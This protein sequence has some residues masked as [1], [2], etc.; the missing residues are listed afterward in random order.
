MTSNNQESSSSRS[1]KLWA[2][3]SDSYNLVF[4]EIAGFSYV[5]ICQLLDTLEA[6]FT[7][8]A[9]S[10]ET[11]RAIKR[12]A[13]EGR[14]IA[15]EIKNEPIDTC[16]SLLLTIAGFGFRDLSS[17]AGVFTAFGAQCR[18]TGHKDVGLRH[19]LPLLSQIDEELNKE[20]PD[21]SLR[22]WRGTIQSVID[23]LRKT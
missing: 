7:G 23:D 18:D 22:R 21:A 6:F 13:A 1:E 8:I 11:T 3:F 14:L 9:R 20:N 4:L 15:A 17:K 16:E 12:Q 5:D 2:A 10:E 19:L